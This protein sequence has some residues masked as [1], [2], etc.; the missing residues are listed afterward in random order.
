[1][2]HVGEDAE[3]PARAPAARPSRSPGPPG[4]PVLRP[5]EF[6]RTALGSVSRPARSWSISCSAGAQM[7]PA[8]PCIVSSTM[9][10]HICRLLVRNS[11]PQMPETLMNSSW[12]IWMILRQSY[13]SAQAPKYTEK[14]DGHPVADDGEA[15][16][17][18]RVEL[19]EQHPVADDVLDA[20]AAH[21]H[22]RADD[23]VTVL[24]IAEGREAGLL[25]G[26]L[27]RRCM[28]RPAVSGT[29][30]GTPQRAHI[31]ASDRSC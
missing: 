18:G 9:A 29:W 8:R 22:R 20:V 23:V 12:A 25:R 17:R 5:V 19:L 15:G 2:Q 11:T 16:Q 3:A 1:M 30:P 13:R 21:R 31:Y 24:R 26:G 10:C 27:R 6:R 14:S 28:R 7:A 4:S